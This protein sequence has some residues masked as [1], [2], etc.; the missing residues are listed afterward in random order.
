VFTRQELIGELSRL[1]DAES[2]PLEVVEFDSQHFAVPSAE[3]RIWAFRGSKRDF[4]SG[5]LFW[6]KTLQAQGWQGRETYFTPYTEGGL[7]EP[8][9]EGDFA[10]LVAQYSGGLRRPLPQF[11]SELGGFRAGL[12]MYA[13]WDDVAVVAELADVFVAFC[14][15]TTA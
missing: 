5:L 12:R 4:P 13:D 15:S 8:I 14:W 9:T 7:C 10:R 1:V 6:V 3:E 2:P 11:L